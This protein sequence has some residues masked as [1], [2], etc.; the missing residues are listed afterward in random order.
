VSWIVLPDTDLI[1]PSTSS[2][3]TGGAGGG[4]GATLVG[5]AVGLTE[6][7]GFSVFSLFA[8]PHA[9]TDNAVAPVTAK[10]TS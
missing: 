4:L 1:S 5:L 3:P 9:A 6:V 7:L 10:V 2:L 8:V